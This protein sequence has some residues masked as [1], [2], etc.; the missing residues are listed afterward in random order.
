MDELQHF[1]VK[2]TFWPQWPQIDIWP[3]TIEGLKLINV[4]ESYCQATWTSY[5]IFSENDL[6]TPVNPNDPR[7][8][9][10]PIT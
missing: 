8:K 9:F 2:M 6:L 1:L 3:H 10:D 7:L 4:Y 5:S